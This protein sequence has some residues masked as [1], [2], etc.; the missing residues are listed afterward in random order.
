MRH[1]ERKQGLVRTP[2]IALTASALE[3]DVE[4]SLAAGCDMHLS[5]PIRKRV[6]L[7]AISE[8]VGVASAALTATA[9]L[10]APS[11]MPETAPM[12]SH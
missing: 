6:L 7:D 1:W 4:Q 10:T 2:I 5:K 3:R 11:R 8:A 9:D 12:P